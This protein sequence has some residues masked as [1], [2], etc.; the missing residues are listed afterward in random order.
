MQPSAPNDVVQSVWVRTSGGSYEVVVGAGLLETV[1]SRLGPLVRGPRCAVIADS[2][3]VSRFS[4]T[5]CRSL[6]EAGFHSTLITVPAGETSKSLEQA[7]AVCEQMAAAGLDR[8]SFVVALGGGVLGDLAGFAAAIYHR[9]VSYVQVPTTLLA[10]VDSSIGGKTAVNTAAAKNLLGAVHQPV[11]V[12]ADVETLRT[13]PKRELNQGFAEI[14]KHAVIADPMMFEV[15]RGFEIP[16]LAELVQRN[17]AIKAAVVALDER[18]A[19]GARAILNFGHTVGHAVER[20]AGYGALLHG[21]AVSLGIVA[22]CEVSVQRAGLAEAERQQVL[23][24]LKRFDMPT[25]LP[26]DFPRAGIMPALRSD[27]KFER[28]EVRFVVSPRLGSAHL[29]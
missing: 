14:I 19:S 1:G 7:G 25:S 17:V 15:L 9:G 23:S 20:A 18:D 28:G 16:R 3:T 21:E 8:S 13:L 11:L 24:A 5:V 2:N 10:Q 12:L 27:K 22:A 6:D 26:A 29:T 4:D